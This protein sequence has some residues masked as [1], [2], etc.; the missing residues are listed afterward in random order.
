MEVNTLNFRI[1]P[2]VDRAHPWVKPCF[3]SYC[4]TCHVVASLFL[5][6]GSKVQIT[7]LCIGW[8]FY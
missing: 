1:L 7:N 6:M 5:A 2:L 3:L 4:L 8:V